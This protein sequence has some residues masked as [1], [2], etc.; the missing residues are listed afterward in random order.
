MIRKRLALGTSLIALVLATSTGLASQ[1]P[2]FTPPSNPAI[3][4]A[5]PA[6][7]QTPPSG[8][9]RIP[10]RI[11]R[12]AA[13]TDTIEL[14]SWNFNHPG[15]CRDEGWVSVDLTAQLGVYF[16]VD[17]FA[18]LGGGS[19]GR[20]LPLQGARSMWCGAR[21]DGISQNLCSYATLPGYGNSW[22]QAICTSACLSVT[23]DVAVDFLVSYDTENTYD[24]FYVEYDRCNEAWSPLESFT[25]RGDG[26]VHE[27]V[28]GGAHTGSVRFRLRFASDE[29]YSDEDGVVNTDGAVIVDSLTVRDAGGIVLGTEL[30]ETEALGDTE[31]A[32]GNWGA[33]TP[34]GYGD[35]AALFH[36]TSVVQFQ[37]DCQT[38]A[39]CLWGFFNNSVY[40]YACGGF[41]S[42]A[43]VPYVNGRGQY[44]RNEVQSPMIAWPGGELAEVQFDRYDDN[45]F[46]ALVFGTW[47]VRS[48]IGGC[49]QPWK[50]IN[51]V[52]AYSSLGW[53]K[54]TQRIGDLI[55]PGATHIQVALGVKDMCGQWCGIYGNGECH[56]NAPLFDNVRVYKLEVT[57]PHWTLADELLFQ[58][59]F[60][61]DGSAT[62][63]ARAD[64]AMDLL[65]SNNGNIRPGDSTVVVVEY[66]G[67]LAT[68]SYTGTGDAVYCYVSVRPQGQPG[69]TGS[70][71]TDDPGRWPVVDSF[72]NG[73]NTWEIIRMDKVRTGAGTPVADK[74]CVDLADN[75]FTPGDTI[76]FV[77]AARGGAPSNKFSYAT[78]A[79]TEYGG[80][81]YQTDDLDWAIKNTDEFT[82]LPA[83]GY[84]RGGD[85]LYVDG[86]NFRGA[87]NY[88]D[89]AFYNMEIGDRVDRFDIRAPEKAVANH[90]GSR[91][92]DVNQQLLG[93]YKKI[94]WNTGN[95]Q[96]AYA[97]ATSGVDKSDDTGILYG[98]INGLQS[99]GGIYLSGDDVAEVWENTL[100]GATAVNL[101]TV[102]INYNLGGTDHEPLTGI[103][104]LMVGET[105][106]IF[107]S[108]FGPDTL[109]AYGGCPLIADF[110]VISPTGPSKQEAT[111]RG[112]GNQTGAIVSEQSINGQGWN[113]GFMLSGFSFDKIRDDRVYRDVP[114]RSW[115]LMR[116]VEW[117]GNIAHVTAAGDPVAREYSLAQNH[118]NPFNPTTTIRYSVAETGH[119]SLRVYNVAG[120]LVR[121]LVDEVQTPGVVGTVTWDG[122]DGAGREVSSG[123]YFYK[124]LAKGFTETK[125]MI[126]LK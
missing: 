29:A 59:T 44:I 18:G 53:T 55:D 35:F 84:L 92:Y 94:I 10:A 69:K 87:Q 15:N 45:S 79:M 43:V 38:N 28:A 126:L 85:I 115:H 23:G 119:V 3:E 67:G 74:Y 71:L 46:N 78:L 104:P 31:T 96:T 97:D 95:L 118:P 26:L 89:T 73:G 121:T 11:N 1:K 101:R 25:A 30:F 51:I 60:P 68:D 7:F 22:D 6:V 41:P 80:R 20:L 83:G 40:N 123:I 47:R 98:F 9:Y 34:P 82:I 125:K 66:P 12:A 32:S 105:L 70:A 77:F 14:G 122:R 63:T 27:V 72:V 109:I 124:L 112:N 13:G 58:D 54:I 114:D 21:P 2:H 76:F 91:V 93:R 56:S 61:N 48:W 99:F 42:Q 62:G 116:I 107:H 110:D 33:C 103:A 65:P 90:P 16:H 113:V 106:G 4:P 17:D 108:A 102:F 57:S 75:L 81:S 52:F 37:D 5:G 120:Q 111:Y 64:M 36:G 49:P 50:D 88:F 86:M 19:F 24:Y 117:L 39:S 100:W 8:D